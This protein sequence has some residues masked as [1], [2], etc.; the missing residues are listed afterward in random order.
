MSKTQTTKAAEMLLEYAELLE[1]EV[2]ELRA[3]ACDKAAKAR[4][5]RKLIPAEQIQEVVDQQE[6]DEAWSLE[7]LPNLMKKVN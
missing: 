4:S 7:G 2:L 5:I 1:K 6:A 3:K